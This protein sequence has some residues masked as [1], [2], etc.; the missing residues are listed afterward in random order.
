MSN[1]LISANEKFINEPGAFER[2]HS[3]EVQIPFLQHT[4]KDFKIVPIVMGQP[5]F[6]LLE[7][8][9]STLNDLV[10][11]RD[12]VLIVVSTDL[13]HYH[14][15]TT[16]RNMDRQAIETVSSMDAQRIYKQ[17]S[18]RKMEMCGF[19][20]VTAALLYA[21]QKGLTENKKSGF[22][23]TFGQMKIRKKQIVSS[24][25]FLIFLNL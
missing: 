24:I 6:S 9:A 20:P 2:E 23:T 21:K 5:S 15:D 19:V 12:D 1:K 18:M 8:F 3:L 14:D 11:K 25:I 22:F 13:S 16:A 4:F 10:G 7:D 17:C